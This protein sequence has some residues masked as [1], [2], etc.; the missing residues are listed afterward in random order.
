MFF[1][2]YSKSTLILGRSLRHGIYSI[3]IAKLQISD[4]STKKEISLINILNKSGPN[5]EPCGIPR[6]TSDH[7]L[8]KEPIAVLCFLKLR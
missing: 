6:E 2:V 5:I 3:V 7:F 8:Y 4:F 1:I